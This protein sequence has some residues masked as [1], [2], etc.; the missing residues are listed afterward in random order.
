[1]E[2]PRLSDEVLT[3]QQVARRLGV[4]VSTVQQLV[5][6]GALTAW[7]TAGGHRRILATSV[8]HYL[9]SR[10]SGGRPA[11]LAAGEGGQLSR[12]LVLEDESMQRTLYQRRFAAWQ[13]P[14][15]IKFCS[16]GYEALIE[17]ALQKPDILL[18][19]LVMPDL[20]GYEVL[21]TITQRSDLGLVHV[22]VLTNKTR[23]EIDALGGLPPGVVYMSKPINFDELHGYLMGCC[24]AQARRTGVSKPP[25]RGIA[26]E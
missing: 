14:A 4:S 22:A 10:T 6:T 11:Q 16:N 19:D 21:Q 17:I 24:A 2:E 20:D 1:M 5:E 9:V 13:L 23:E 25:G 12:I 8:S 7:K 18:L 26:D 15:Q 3:T